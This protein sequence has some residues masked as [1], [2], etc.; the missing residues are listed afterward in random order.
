[1]LLSAGGKPSL[2]LSSIYRTL[3]NHGHLALVTFQDFNASVVGEI[4]PKAVQANLDHFGAP[5]NFQNATFISGDWGNLTQECSGIETDR[6][7]LI[8]TADTIYNTDY[9]QKLYE[10]IR[11]NLSKEGV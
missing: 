8:L 4:T 2:F 5:D 6:F 11:A 7:D 9:F 3:A 10:Y 1:M